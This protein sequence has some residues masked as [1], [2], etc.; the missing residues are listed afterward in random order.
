M[1]TEISL[2]DSA[3]MM[4]GDA[5]VKIFDLYSSSLYSYALRMCSDP[6]IADNIVGDVFAKLL[7][8]FSSGNGP[9]TN[10]RSYLYETAYHLVVDEARNT[11]RGAPLEVV[12]GLEY[13]PFSSYVIFENNILVENIMQAIRRDLTS[14]QRHVV[15]LR[16]LEGFSLRETA[17]ILGKQVSNVKVI[18]NRAI[19]ILRK[20]LDYVVI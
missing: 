9:N 18:Q 3:K 1:D 13:D 16:F 4:N 17:T 2:L 14:D 5:L 7:D 10:L 19:A 8:Q 12:D 20:A 6:L 15:I 11:Q